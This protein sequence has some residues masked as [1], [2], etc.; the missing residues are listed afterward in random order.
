[1]FPCVLL[2]LYFSSKYY[3]NITWK[4]HNRSACFNWKCPFILLARKVHTYFKQ[5][6]QDFADKD[7]LWTLFFSPLLQTVVLFFSGTQDLKSSMSLQEGL[8]SG[9]SLG[10]TSGLVCLFTTRGPSSRLCPPRCR[11]RPPL[12]RRWTVALGRR[13]EGSSQTSRRLTTTRSGH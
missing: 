2:M 8:L 4:V 3:T 12:C 6:W 7:T 9:I 13:E 5:P 1:M 11:R 10:A